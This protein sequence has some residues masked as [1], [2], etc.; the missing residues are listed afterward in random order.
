VTA[1]SAQISVQARH[2]FKFTFA[3]AGNIGSVVFLYCDNGALLSFPC[4]APPGLDVSSASLSSQTGNVGFS[5]DS[6]DTTTN[7]LVISRASTPSAQVASTYDFSNITNPSTPG[8]TEFI[9]ITTYASTDGSGAYTDNGTVAFS[10]VNPFDINTFVPPFL[11]L[12]VGLTVV[13]NCSNASGNLVELGVL[14]PVHANADT[15]QFSAGTN[16]VSGYNIYVLGNTMTSGNNAISNLVVPSGSTPG[17]SQFGINLRA[18][19]NPAVGQNPNGPGTAA[20]TGNYN[21]TNLF[22][23]NPGDNIAAVNKPSDYRRMTVSYLVNV[24]G[25]QPPGY[26]NTTLTYL[27]TA[28]F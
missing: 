24:S 9:R 8:N 19:S 11:S 2:D 27:A 26:Y 6:A 15:S 12:C 14:S 4:N 16:S 23:F 3:T 20:P 13:T 22:T 17:T 21:S 18:N 10:T 1:S 25:G 5:I 7:K 28:D